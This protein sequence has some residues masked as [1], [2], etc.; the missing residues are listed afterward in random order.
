MFGVGATAVLL[1]LGMQLRGSIDS[2]LC[3]KSAICHSFYGFSV[4][5]QQKVFYIQYA[6]GV[7]L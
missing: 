3:T 2:R 5:L 7:C 6:L 4:L 1:C